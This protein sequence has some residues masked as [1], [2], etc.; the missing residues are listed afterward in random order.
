MKLRTRLSLYFTLTSS[1]ILLL[2]L[3]AVYFTFS[4]FLQAD[5]FE[6]LT[7]RTM[8]TAKL[9]LEA[10]EISRD[11]L[12]KVR[13]SYLRTLNSEVIRIYNSRNS[14]EFIGDDQ[15]YWDAKTINLVRSRKKIQFKEGQ[16]QVVGIFYKDNQ[17]DF[18]IL[19]S[20]IDESNRN[21]MMELL[22]IMV[23][24]FILIFVC[25]LLFGQ[26]IAKNMLSPLDLLINDVKKVKSN[27]LGYRVSTGQNK[28]E[29][30]LV[31]ENFNDLM[32]H[33]E[34]AFILQKTF[35]AN[36]SHELRTPITSMFITSELALSKDRSSDE[37]KQALHSVL[38]DADKMDKTISGLLEL[39]QADLAYE[40]AAKEP[41]RIDEL[42]WQLE[43]EW[44]NK[45][46]S[47]DLKIEIPELPEVEEDLILFGNA[48]QL[49]IA[50]NNIIGN[51]FKFSDGKPVIAELLVSLNSI[52]IKITDNGVG[53]PEGEMD[54]IF[55]P[56]YSRSANVVH[57]G[58]GMGL[59]MAQKIIKLLNGKLSVTSKIGI[60]SAFTIEFPKF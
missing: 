45:G 6:R 2:V 28:D 19:A 60:G 55:Q 21:R 5:F 17:G 47:R 4:K 34:N 3:G 43:Q 24:I 35:V 48:A 59:Y 37:Y 49:Q 18:V 40:P 10:D 32:D 16:R 14:A 22:K 36:A 13:N 33:L 23:A 27:N 8:V 1:L 54:Q 31:A 38:E 41:I 12:N 15:Q 25:L 42:L 26:W 51:A 57:Q 50:L 52:Q 44:R 39:A 58:T 53:I 30:A 7:D 46:Q 9:Y 11:S 56:F 20:A 29:I